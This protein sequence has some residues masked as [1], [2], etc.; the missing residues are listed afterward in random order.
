MLFTSQSITSKQRCTYGHPLISV[1]LALSMR[2]PHS[3]FWTLPIECKCWTMV[4][5]LQFII[6]S[7][8]RV[9]WRGSL[10]INEFKRSSSKPEVLPESGVSLMSKRSSLKQENNFLAVLSP[11]AL[12]PYTAHMFL[13]ASAAFAPYW[14]QREEYVANVPIYPTD[15][16]F[17]NVHGSTDYIQMT[18][19]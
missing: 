3:R 19:L 11:M 12:S 8:S 10:W 18:K 5:W 17:S 16:I 13:V 9:N 1:V 15:T 14:T 4:E 7:S 6:F 2:H